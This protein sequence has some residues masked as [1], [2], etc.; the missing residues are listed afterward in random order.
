MCP[1][2][3][4]DTRIARR[5]FF[6]KH[7]GHATR[8]QRYQCRRCKRWFS[9]QTAAL[10]YR[11]KKPQVNQPLFRMLATGVSQRAAAAYLGIHP[12]TVARK[13]RR[14]GRAARAHLRALAKA[15]PAAGAVVFDEMETFEHT[16]MKPLSIALAVE[17]KTRRILAVEV[18]SMPAK[19]LLADRSRRKY[20][21]RP[22]HRPIALGAMCREVKRAHPGV[23]IVKS[24][25]SPRYPGVVAKHFGGAFHETHKGRRA[26]VVG[27]GE[28]KAIGRDPLFSLNHTAA[29]V[30]DNLKTMSRRTWCTCKRP[31]RLQ[32][33]LY[34]YAWRH[35]QRLDKVPLRRM[36]I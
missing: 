31:D 14:Q 3:L 7:A 30:R 13:L 18:A 36:K 34:I 24:D 20:G 5:G 16:K 6:K 23:L 4:Q 19:G 2:C 25:E 26:C 11:E 9:D 32:Y 10:S 33:L 12:I 28:L 29:M 22:D 27:Q 15:R 17:E 8:V 35:Q 1:F 21:Y